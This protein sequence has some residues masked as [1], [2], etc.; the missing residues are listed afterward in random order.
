MTMLDVFNQEAFQVI[1]LTDNINKLDHVPGRIGQMGI[2]T[3]TSITTSTAVIEERNDLLVL[4]PT[5]GRGGPGFT[6]DKLKRTVRTLVVPH[7]EINDAIMAEEVQGIRAW[8]QETAVEQVFTKVAERGQIHSQSLEATTEFARIGAVR[9]IVVYPEGSVTSDLNL[10]TE[11][12]V[13]QIAETNFDLSNLADG[14][15]RELVQQTIRLLID[16]LGNISFE[17]IHALCGNQFFDDLI[18]NVEVRASYLGQPEATVLR[19]GY[20][21]PNGDKIYGAFEFGGMVW[22]NYRGKV[23]SVDYVNTDKCHMFPMGVPGLFRTIWSPADYIETVNTPGQRLTAKQ[24]M[25]PNDKGVHFDVQMNEL[26]Y[27]TRPRVLLQGR[28]A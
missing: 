6:L 13:T 4:I 1:T 10:F 12:G 7:Y 14:A 24:Y 20:V 22:E 5:T 25:M 3:P 23:G 2:F 19:D 26:N 15:L 21:R 28:R 27:C 8:G 18:K 9:G 16:E 17:H 11:F